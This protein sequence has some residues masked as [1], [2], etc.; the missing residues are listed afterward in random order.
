MLK[1]RRNVAFLAGAALVVAAPGLPCYEAAAQV[2][3]SASRISGGGSAR[4]GASGASIQERSYPLDAGLSAPAPSLAPALQ[5]ALMP[6]LELG[7]ATSPGMDALT[8]TAAAPGVS[9]GAL[10]VDKD[11]VLKKISTMPA[12]QAKKS[13][14]AIMD[15]ALRVKSISQAADE[16]AAAGASVVDI[17]GHRGVLTPLSSPESGLSSSHSGDSHEV[18]GPDLSGG[19]VNGGGPGGKWQ[20]FKTGFLRVWHTATGILSDKAHNNQFWVFITGQAL[21]VFGIAFFHTALA[22]LVVGAAMGYLRA[23]NWGFQAAASFG[24]GPLIDKT[25]SSKI[26]VSTFLGR[27]VFLIAAAPLLISGHYIFAGLAVIVAITSFLQS[28]GLNAGSAVFTRIL[29]NDRANYNKANAVYNLWI[30][31][32]GTLGNLASIWFISYVGEH[33]AWLAAH[34]GANLAVPLICST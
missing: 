4:L 33:A 1:W 26:F 29:G 13:S 10:L 8:E 5:A 9:L 27:A 6:N 25:S 17:E 2:V 22:G 16:T 28:M 15:E 34:F 32:I 20:R 31:G 7:M 14:D 24:T 19:P 18:P 21:I 12:S 30:D 11:A 3:Q 23:I